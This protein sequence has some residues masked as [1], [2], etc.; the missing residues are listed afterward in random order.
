M[1]KTPDMKL[2]DQIAEDSNTN[3]D[4]ATQ[5]QQKAIEDEIAVQQPLVAEKTPISGVENEYIATGNT[6]FQAKARDLAT[7]YKFI[8]RIRG[9]GNCFYRALAFA[10]CERLLGDQIVRKKFMNEVQSWKN[11]L[12][13]LGF[14]EMTTEDFCDTFFDTVSKF[15]TE[16]DVT[17]VFCNQAES[18]YLVVF[19]R[20]VTSGY[21]QENAESYADFV[22]GDMTLKQY[23]ALEIEPMDKEC[24]HLC[25]VA[26]TKA[27]G[28]LRG[29]LYFAVRHLMSGCYTSRRTG[30]LRAS[31]AVRFIALIKEQ[32]NHN[33]VLR[34]TL[35]SSHIMFV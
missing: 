35:I 12:L 32:L 14:P 20:L 4:E 29:Q 1:T 13:K 33:T 30:M 16:E 2:V 21:L 34:V 24:D 18:N 27:M 22:E 25:I 6:I 15:Q 31:N 11:R 28:K 9:D 5:Q 7:R 23:C 3:I 19:M 8:R 17:N 10:Q 26:L